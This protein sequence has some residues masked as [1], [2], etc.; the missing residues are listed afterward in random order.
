MP[1]QST[2]NN[3]PDIVASQPQAT[4]DTPASNPTTPSP[5]IWRTCWHLVLPCLNV[6]LEVGSAE[7]QAAITARLAKNTHLTDAQ[8]QQIANSVSHAIFNQG[9]LSAKALNK[10]IDEH[11]NTHAVLVEL[12]QETAR[13]IGTSAKDFIDISTQL[14]QELI[15]KKLAAKLEHVGLSETDAAR[16]TQAINASLVTQA[17]LTEELIDQSMNQQIGIFTAAKLFA[18]STA[19]NVTTTGQVFIDVG[20][21]IAQ[22]KLKDRLEDSFSDIDPTLRKIMIDSIMKTTITQMNLTEAALN[23]LITTHL[24]M[25][26]DVKSH[27]DTFVTTTQQDAPSEDSALTGEV[28]STFVGDTNA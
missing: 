4:Q 10:I 2:N 20:T 13:N 8:K 6:L 17:N 1:N 9:H 7:A 25:A 12:A 14:G 23:T 16:L 11:T 3:T 28:P 15:Q 22:N 24:S 26:N 27:I 19:A 5:S 18:A 21:E